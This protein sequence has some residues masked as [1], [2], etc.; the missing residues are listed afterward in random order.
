ML[1][2]LAVRNAKPGIHLDKHGLYLNVSATGKKSWLLRFS[3]QGR[4]PEM[5]LGSFDEL[6][7]AEARDAATA[8][9]TL[10]RAGINPIEAKHAVKVQK[11]A[12]R[13]FGE[14][15][16]ELIKSKSSE[17][18]N[19]K[20]QDQWKVSLEKGAAALRPKPVDLISTADIL[21]VLTPIWL[22]TPESASR[23]R[24]RIEAVLNAAKAKGLRSGDNPAT[25]RGHL[26]HLLP[27]RPAVA[28]N[29]FAAIDYQQLPTFMKELELIDSVSA[30]AL[31]FTILTAA[32]SGETYG[33]T[34]PEI[35]L[36]SRVW[37]IPAVRMKS[38]REHRV[39]LSARAI[40]IIEF[41]ASRK[42]SEFIFPGQRLN[43]PLSHVAMAKVIER[44]HVT[45]A[46]VHGFRSAFRDWAG[47]ETQFSREICEAALAHVVGDAAEQA[48]RRGDALEKRRLLMKEWAEYILF[49]AKPE[50]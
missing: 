49:T 16:D 17:W 38:G 36:N 27:K 3:W 39:P 15:A 26:E 5:S 25:W 11:Q 32:R 12:K 24:Q 48:Y 20:H 7:L 30:R 46:T 33:A 18:R 21:E 41:Q 19:K 22:K 2:V 35:D 42:I 6:S 43:K 4:R 9:R 8:A 10:V 45:G 37:I 29:H 50:V 28:R 34:W 1:T 40:E 13:L 23:M 31:E 47:N 44:M 14:V